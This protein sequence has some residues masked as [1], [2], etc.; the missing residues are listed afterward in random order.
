MPEVMFSLP[1]HHLS[2]F[3]NHCIKYLSLVVLLDTDTFCIVGEHKRRSHK[4]T[5][6]CVCWFVRRNIVKKM[7]QTT[8]LK[9]A[10]L[11]F[12]D[13]SSGRGSDALLTKQQAKPYYS[14]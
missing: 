2:S 12:F 1:F 7:R 3:C 6:A 11:N 4:T 8:R 9:S 14:T 10:F 13:N 5:S